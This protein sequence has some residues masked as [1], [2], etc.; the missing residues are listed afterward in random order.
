MPS[1]WVTDNEFASHRCEVMETWMAHDL[2]EYKVLKRVCT[3]LLHEPII[4]P[5][6]TCSNAHFIGASRSPDMTL[7][8][9]SNRRFYCRRAV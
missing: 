5:T 6:P 4:S 3:I 1:Y 9:C 7:C 8:G 2:H